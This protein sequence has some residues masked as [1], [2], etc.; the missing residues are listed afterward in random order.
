MKHLISMLLLLTAAPLVA[1]ADSSASAEMER[2]Q[3]LWREM[4]EWYIDN[5]MPEQALDMVHRLREG[6]EST[7]ELDLIQARALMAQGTPEEARHI[8]EEVVKR[9]PHDARPLESLGIIYADAG[10]YE[11]AV[12]VMRKALVEAE[13]HVPTRNN[14][15]FVL[16]GMGRCEEAVEEL[17]KVLDAD[18]T[19]ARY[20][21]NLAFALVCQGDGQRALKLFRSTGPEA[22]ARYNMGIAYE[23]LGKF[24]SAILQYREALAADPE[25]VGAR[26]ALATLESAEAAPAASAGADNPLPAPGGLTP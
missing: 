11:S 14:L 16:M 4:A 19:N 5:H 21:N 22:D 23:R 18:G 7:V 2:K 9:Y 6:G 20:R 25:H 17:Q 3:S 15:G 13:D 26:E 1:H 24:P 10:D 12:T 8:L